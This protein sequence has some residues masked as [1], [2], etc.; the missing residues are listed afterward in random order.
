MV[1]GKILDYSLPLTLQY[2]SWLSVELK[3]YHM[4]SRGILLFLLLMS[5]CI[6]TPSEGV[7]LSVV[8]NKTRTRAREAL[9]FC[10]TKSYNMDFCILVDMS[11]HSGLK[12]FFV[13]DF[14]GDSIVNRFMVAHGCCNQPWGL[15]AT[16]DRPGF[17]NVDGSL[18]SSLG[19]FKVGER[20]YSNWG[21]HVKYN[22]HGLEASNK[23]ALARTIVLHSW[24]EITDHEV[25]PAGTAEGWGCPVLSNKSLRLLDARLKA[26]Q[27]PVLL[28]IYQ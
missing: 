4:N 7:V 18:C 15:D 11:L 5:S 23:N 2:F 8:E 17:S 28:W 26:V 21:I 22:L 19:K 1:N 3:I 20:G 12:R 24:E 27:Q 10:K 14:K 6:A 25:Y 9:I 16:R 13:W